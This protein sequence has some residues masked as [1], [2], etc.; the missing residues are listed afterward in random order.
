MD[1][2][3]ISTWSPLYASQGD[4]CST[5]W[6]IVKLYESWKAPGVS[7]LWRGG[8]NGTVE[9]LLWPQDKYPMYKRYSFNIN[10]LLWYISSLAHL[11]SNFT[12]CIWS[13]DTPIFTNQRPP[14]PHLHAHAHAR[15]HT[16]THT[17]AISKGTKFILFISCI[18]DHLLGPRKWNNP[19]SLRTLQQTT[20]ISK[21]YMVLLVLHGPNKHDSNPYCCDCGKTDVSRSWK[22]RLS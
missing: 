16:D 8:L 4:A 3:T 20:Q 10:G 14:S 6:P 11:R 17:Q 7:K 21:A 9:C 5:V 15:T 13:L 2:F 1:M 12:V 22:L 19:S 18:H